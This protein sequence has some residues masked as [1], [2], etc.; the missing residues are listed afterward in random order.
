MVF[1]NPLAQPLL[2][3]VQRQ[4]PVLR[5]AHHGL[6]AADGAF[7]INQVCR[8]EAGAALLALVT[9]GTFG[10]AVGALA[11]DVT[12]GKERLGFLVVVLHTG[13]FDE[14]FLVIQFAEEVGSRVVM[15]L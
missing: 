14:F 5:L 11:G 12:V 1:Q 6:A 3:L 4:I 7:R 10:M 9:V 13:L 8:A 2:V 15:R